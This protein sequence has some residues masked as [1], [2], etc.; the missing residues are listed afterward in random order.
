[1]P[2]LTLDFKER[3]KKEEISKKFGVTGIPTFVLLDGDSGDIICKNARNQ[4]QHEDN[5]GENFP[6]KSDE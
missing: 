1:M 4:I 5:K 2:W 6:W 3:K